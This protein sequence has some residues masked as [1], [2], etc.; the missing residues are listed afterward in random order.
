METYE[1]TDEVIDA[2]DDVVTEDD[3]G[4]YL[5]VLALL[6]IGAAAGAAA[7]KGY[8]K[9]KGRARTFVTDAKERADSPRR[10]PSRPSRAVEP[11]GLM[12]PK[13]SSCINQYMGFPGLSVTNEGSVVQFVVVVLIV[14]GCT[15]MVWFL[16]GLRSAKTWSCCA[17]KKSETS[18]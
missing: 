16:V 15:C 3:R 8:D 12:V 6:G 17:T 13:G 4:A 9:V 14:F 5:T 7:T 2:T 10:R 11:G 1:T 18:W